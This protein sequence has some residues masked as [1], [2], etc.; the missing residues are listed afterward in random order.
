MSQK[1]IF[2]ASGQAVE[3]V[4]ELLMNPDSESGWLLYDQSQEK[5]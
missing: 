2:S 3:A 1:L 4:T 5:I